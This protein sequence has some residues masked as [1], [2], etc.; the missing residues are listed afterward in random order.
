M[1]NCFT[2]I[3]FLLLWIALPVGAIAGCQSQADVSLPPTAPVTPTSTAPIA[4]PSATPMAPTP[5]AENN[6]E[7]SLTTIR[8]DTFPYPVVDSFSKS[9]TD[10]LSGVLFH[11]QRNTLFAVRDNG[12]II[13]METDGTIIRAEIVQKKADFEGITVNPQTGLLYV[14]VEGNEVILEVDPET[15]NPTRAIPIDRVFEQNLL[16][17]PGGDGIEGITFVPT[18]DGTSAGTFFL[19]NQSDELDGGDPSI[20]FEVEIN[21][22]NS[23]LYARIIRYFSVDVT[24]LSGIQYAPTTDSLLIISDSN[25]LLLDVSL[26]G[27]VLATY[28]LPG[29]KQEGITLDE[30]GFL[31]IAHDEKKAPLLKYGLPTNLPKE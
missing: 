14:A 6:I 26:S 12:Q 27:Q 11:P 20:V 17:A 4:I 7:I 19:L 2:P 15:L 10:E 25:N 23:E 16:L 1:K 29:K 31:Y 3:R 9:H 22:D 30:A 24:D 13:E 18:N 8:H 5:T 28:P 21:N